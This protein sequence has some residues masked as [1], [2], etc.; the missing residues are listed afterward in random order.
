MNSNEGE[1]WYKDDKLRTK[2]EHL[3][4]RIRIEKREKRYIRLQEVNE[5][6]V[7]HEFQ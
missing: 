5:S 4:C 6:K 1:F 3:A 7:R 2:Q